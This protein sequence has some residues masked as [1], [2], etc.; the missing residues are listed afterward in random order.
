M[1]GGS[2][3]RG[4]VVEEQSILIL[5]IIILILLIIMELCMDFQWV[6]GM[7]FDDDDLKVT[8]YLSA[9]LSLGYWVKLRRGTLY[10]LVH[11]V[12]IGG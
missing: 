12:S 1:R 10:S 9:S 6:W 4:G 11:F 3:E 7:K 8:W 2:R 5:I